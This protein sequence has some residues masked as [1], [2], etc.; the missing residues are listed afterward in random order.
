MGYCLSK[1]FGKSKAESGISQKHVY[2]FL[3]G[4]SGYHFFEEGKGSLQFYHF[5]HEGFVIVTVDLVKFISYQLFYDA[6]VLFGGTALAA[7]GLFG[8]V[9]AA[10]GL[11]AS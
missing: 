1:F 9:G 11:F 2:F 3:I 7:R 10:H 4:E 6:N 8:G 5:F